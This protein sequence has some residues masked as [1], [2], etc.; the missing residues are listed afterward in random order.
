MSRLLL[1]FVS[2]VMFL[3]GRCTGEAS[4]LSSHGT[5]LVS[6]PTESGLVVC[7]DKREWNEIRGATD[8]ITKIY[9]V[10][11][12]AA[13]ALAGTNAVLNRT[14]LQPMFSIKALTQKHLQS[15]TEQQLFQKIVTLPEF[16]N[17]NYSR[18]HLETGLKLDHPPYVTDDVVYSIIIWH[19]SK[20]KVMVHQVQCHATG[21]T[22]CVASLR[23]VTQQLG[24][25][26]YLDGQT[27]FVLAAIRQSDPR[28]KSFKDDPDIRTVW[29]SSN[30]KN[31]SV[32]MALRFAR[33]TIRDTNQFHH[34]VSTTETMVSV[35]ADCS[36]MNP[37]RG[38]EWLK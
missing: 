38:F 31:I 17:D 13:F 4:S 3:S 33:K 7:S 22:G 11:R 34:L 32:E 15:T 2:L 20:A 12:R 35:G 36:L 24:Q 26:A 28:F 1:S 37:S 18:F 29:T 27:N 30:P 6:V 8:G 10:N 9:V 5:L 21:E 16:L 19:I 23:D 14:T 25:R